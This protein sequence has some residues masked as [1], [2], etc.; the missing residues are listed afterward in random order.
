MKRMPP[1]PLLIYLKIPLEVLLGKRTNGEFRHW[2]SDFK[3]R[4]TFPIIDDKSQ[5]LIIVISEVEDGLF[6]C[7]IR[8]LSGTG[9]K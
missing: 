3:N 6:C 1:R 2:G 8:L 4:Y 5:L 9:E 7:E